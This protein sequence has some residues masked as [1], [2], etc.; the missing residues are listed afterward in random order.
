ML[1]F[2]LFVLEDEPR[3]LPEAVAVSIPIPQTI[4]IPQPGDGS[5]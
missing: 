5:S 4:A 3:E 1:G 2:R